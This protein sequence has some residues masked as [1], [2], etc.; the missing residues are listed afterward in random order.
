MRMRKVSLHCRKRGLSPLSRSS[1]PIRDVDLKGCAS[2][3]EL[4]LGLSECWAIYSGER[5]HQGLGNRTPE[6][7]HRSSEGGGAEI[8]DRFG[9]A[10]RRCH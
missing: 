6:A 7:V 8:V 10:P 5:P 2:L 4:L 1:T 3:P 9:A